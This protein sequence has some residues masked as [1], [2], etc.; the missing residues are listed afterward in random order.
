MMHDEAVL[1]LAFS[2]D[3]ELLVSGGWVR[4]KGRGGGGQGVWHAGDV[5]IVDVWV[6]QSLW[7]GMTA[8]S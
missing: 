2:R 7:P 5:P 3:S 8:C 4:V 6:E 1:A